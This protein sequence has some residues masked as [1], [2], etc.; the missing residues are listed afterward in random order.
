LDQKLLSR[1]RRAFSIRRRK[2]RAAGGG[3]SRRRPPVIAFENVGVGDAVD[4]RRRR[5][6]AFR[7]ACRENKFDGKERAFCLLTETL[8]WPYQIGGDRGSAKAVPM[9]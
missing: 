1:N 8:K 9:T 5:E 2:R 4:H 6:H 3:A 7:K